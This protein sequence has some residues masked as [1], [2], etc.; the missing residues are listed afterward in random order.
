MTDLNPRQQAAVHYIDGPLLVLAGAGSGKTRVITTKIGHL[1]KQCSIEPGCITAV[2]FTNKAA[3]KM[4]ERVTKILT[5][6]RQQGPVISTFHTL[7]LNILRRELKRLG[8]K[9][10]FSI[11]DQQDSTTILKDLLRKQNLGN[12]SEIN[13]I[14][15]IISGWKNGLTTPEQALD[16][17]QDDLQIRQAQLYST[18]QR[19]LK[20]FNAFD[21]DDLILAPITLFREHPDAL[22]SWRNRIRYLLVDEY[23]DTN[24]TQY[25]LVNQLV[26]VRA[27]FTVVGD[28]DQSI[29]AWRG[30]RPENLTRLQSDFPRL[31]LIKLEQNY[32]SSGRILKSA[33]QLISNNPHVHKKL[34]WSE[35]GPV[36]EL[37]VLECR[38]EEQEAEKVVSEII[39]LKFMAKAANIDFAIL[40][41]GNHQAKIFEKALRT[42]NIPYFLSGGTSFFAR[43]EVKDAMAYLRLLA[44]PDDDSAF[45]RI[46]NTPRREIGPT[47]LEKLSGYAQQREIALLPACNE[48]GVQAVLNSRAY[49]RLQHFSQFIGHYTQKADNNP[50]EAIGSL[51]NEIE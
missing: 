50:V 8:Y 34:L 25:E 35:L 48:V 19:S 9:V 21:F 47:T 5:R 12:E 1:V 11:F 3:R 30:A 6:D 10:G 27:A 26:G 33:N 4:K 31:K 28:D 45:L 18:Y 49:D 7:G 14:Q 16:Q 24:Q 46:I 22:E 17:A 41:R 44:N 40:Y 15:W 13:A 20:A 43:T 42:H 23:Q 29:Y 2:T 51:V 39:H 37:R 38:N 36:P 32:R